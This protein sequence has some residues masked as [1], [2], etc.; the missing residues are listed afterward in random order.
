M[1]FAKNISLLLPLAALL[2]IVGCG[3]SGNSFRLSGT[4][5]GM[6]NGELYIYNSS[7]EN[8]RF[9]TVMVKDGKFYY[10]GTA[11]E[12][13]PYYIIYPNAL[14]QTVFLG[15]GE[16][17]SYEAVSNDLNNYVT[18]GSKENK[19][20]TQFRQSIKNA[21]YSD[22]QAKARKFI[23]E[24]AKSNVALYLFEHYFVQNGQTSYDE[25]VRVMNM[26]KPVH[27]E[28]SYFTYLSAK[29]KSMKT[30]G[31]D[32]V[33][34]E[35]AMKTKGDKS[36]KLWSGKNS[37]NYTLFLVWSTWIPTSYEII[38]KVRQA[39][40]DYPKS[41]LRLVAYSIDN[42]YDRW[43]NMTRYDSLTNIEHYCDTRAFDAPGINATRTSII[44]TY[45][46]MDSSH[47][48][49]AKG[50]EPNGLVED[51][52]KFVGKKEE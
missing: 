40:K 22:I 45:Y 24:E 4:I 32:D 28:N 19:L 46:L 25:L 17:I 15:P 20:L 42:E 23:S 10:G 21:S 49:I 5:E 44:P 36:V 12:P 35:I 41:K 50:S 9:D 38:A 6:Q 47:K 2:I 3:P 13:T 18:S 37:S 39:E 48:V 31:I 51:I 1:K 7:L 30:V 11:D 33:F 16:E 8:A 29:V 52:A 34:P 43:Y 14:E 27:S 26:L